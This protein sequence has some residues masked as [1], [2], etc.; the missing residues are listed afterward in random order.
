VKPGD[1]VGSGQTLGRAGVESG[2][3][4]YFEVRFQGRPEDPREWLQKADARSRDR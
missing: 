4:L 2:A 1:K 3:D